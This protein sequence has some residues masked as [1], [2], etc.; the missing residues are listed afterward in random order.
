M[1]LLCHT[2]LHVILWDVDVISTPARHCAA[3]TN[4]TFIV[5][6]TVDGAGAAPS[7]LLI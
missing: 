5:A 3:I 7:A 1:V 6:D 2:I 4:T